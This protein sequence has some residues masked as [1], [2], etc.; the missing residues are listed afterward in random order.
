VNYFDAIE[1][2]IFASDSKQHEILVR[3]INTYLQE[4]DELAD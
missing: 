4:P 3:S 1:A 2:A